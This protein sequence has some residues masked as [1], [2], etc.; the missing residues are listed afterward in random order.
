[1]ARLEQTMNKT[2]P[3]CVLIS[4]VRNEAQHIR[5]TIESMIAQTVKPLKWVIVNDGSTDETADIVKSYLNRFPW[6]D[7]ME[8]PQRRDRTFAAKVNGFNAGY[9]RVKSL[10][11]HVV[12]NLDGDVSFDPDHLEFVLSKFAEDPTLGVGGT[13]FRE[14]GYSSDRNSFEGQAHVPGQFQLFRRQCFEEIGGYVAHRHGGIDWMAC[15]TARLRGWKTKAF[16]ERV[17]FHH[18]HLGTAERGPFWA[19]FSYG[20]KDYYLGGSPIWQFFRVGYRL[21][22][23]PYVVGGV[24]LGLGYLWALVRR[25][26]RP[27]SD[28]L[29]R[30]HRREQM[31]ALKGI[32]RSVL[33]LK[34]V[35]RFDVAPH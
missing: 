30:F 6:I 25:M 7:L 11:F 34:G 19:A 33:R 31:T 22:N 23:R 1:M 35:D 12:G 17:F 21:I 29:M 20:E 5:Q 26:D 14:E 27:V 2:L 13:I 3:T 10:D 8:M 24:A 16:R 18:R 28:E 4:P 32:L 15:G 9:E